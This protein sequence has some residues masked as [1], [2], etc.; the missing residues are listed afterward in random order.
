[1]EVIA[2]DAWMN[3]GVWLP[4]DLIRAANDWSYQVRISAFKEARNI[5]YAKATVVGVAA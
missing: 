3:K 5:A 4:E 1:M 2:A